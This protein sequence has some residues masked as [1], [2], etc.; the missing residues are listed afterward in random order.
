MKAKEF[1]AKFVSILLAAVMTL[2]LTVPALAAYDTPTFSDVP[3]EFWGYTYIEQAAEKGWVKGMGGGK[4]EPN[5]KVTYAQFATMLDQAFFKDEVDSYGVTNPWFTRFCNVAGEKG[6]F[7][8]TD[9]ENYQNAGSYANRQ[10]S[11]Y[12]MAQVVYNTLGKI[13]AKMPSSKEVAAQIDTTPDFFDIP[14]K[15]SIAV[16]T[17]KASGIISGMG[18]GRFEGDGTLTRAQ[19]CVVL[20]KLDELAGTGDGTGGDTEPSGPVE[21]DRSPFAF[22]DGENVQQMMDRLN[23]E[24]P[25]YYKGYLTNGKPVTEANIKEMLAAAEK[26]MPSRTKWDGSSFYNYGS[27][28][29][30]QYTYCEG[31]AAFVAALSD[32]IFGKDA[33][34]I[35]HQNFDNLK[36]GDFIEGA[37]SKTGYN[38]SFLITSIHP[39]TAD[40]YQNTNG[41]LGGMVMW[42]CYQYASLWD[43][44]TRAESYVYSRY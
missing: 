1:T 23:A 4:F 21:I 17:A 12:E 36:V 35:A 32:Y 25:K 42:D 9:A 20:I 18:G 3:P 41:N 10:M 44:T 38:H 2:G 8:G 43:E 34:V 24:A 33:P 15:Y 26:S 14:S 22:K 39:T 16:L 19:T 7:A 5:G 30:G 27:R 11:R 37:N 13:N 6:L 40:S 31:C 28:A 29:Y